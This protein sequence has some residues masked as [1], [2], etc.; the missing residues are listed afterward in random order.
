M[1][2]AESCQLPGTR[3]TEERCKAVDIN[4]VA[5]HPRDE[6]H[7]ATAPHG[8]YEGWVYLGVESV[9]L[10]ENGEP[11]EVV[12]RVRCRRCAAAAEDLT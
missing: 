1:A 10:D 11:D 6:D 5:H 3:P 12:L 8:C 9:E 2:P 4:S 7:P